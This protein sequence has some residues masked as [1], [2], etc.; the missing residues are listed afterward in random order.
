MNKFTPTN[1]DANQSRLKITWADG[2]AHELGARLLRAACNCASCV[3]EITGQR[4]IDIAKIRAD[5][6]IS[7]A[8]PTGN[9]AVSLTFS[10]FHST[11]IFTYEYLRALGENNS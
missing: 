5:I 10:D 6:S 4:L 11:G 9:Y 8:E 3:S 2:V 7:K 1:V